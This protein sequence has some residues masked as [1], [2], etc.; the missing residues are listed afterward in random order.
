MV[1]TCMLAV[2]SL[3]AFCIEPS[4]ATPGSKAATA[5]ASN[6]AAAPNIVT[7]ANIAGSVNQPATLPQARKPAVAACAIW[8]S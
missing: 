6:A 1:A 3:V 2:E 8:Q 7:A 5:G 4:G